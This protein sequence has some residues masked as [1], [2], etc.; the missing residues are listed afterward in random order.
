MGALDR[1]QVVQSALEA[2]GARDVKFFFKLDL[3]ATPRSD[4]RNG[5][6]HF[7][8][9]YLKGRSTKVERIGDSVQQA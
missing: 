1:L 6:A 9:A 5:I 2:R 8:D 7:L 3:A 4:V